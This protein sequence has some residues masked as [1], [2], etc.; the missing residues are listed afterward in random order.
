MERSKSGNTPV[1]QRPFLPTAASENLNCII[2]E[3]SG[4]QNPP[5]THPPKDGLSKLLRKT[6]VVKDNISIAGTRMTCGSRLLENY[7]SPFTATA[8]Q[9]LANAGVRF[10]GKTNLDEFAMGSSNE[11]SCFGPVPNPFDRSRVA[12]GSSGG[13]AA[14]AAAGLADFAL[15]SD[16][17]GS[18]R[19][20]AAFCGVLGFKPTFGR[21]SRYG[22]TAHASSL[23][24]IG[25]LSQSVELVIQAFLCM[26][27]PDERDST[28]LSGSDE[29]PHA[30]MTDFK[31][32]RIGAPTLPKESIDSEISDRL[33]WVLSEMEKSGC[34]I[35][36]TASI[37]WETNLAVYYILS[38]A[39]AATN[40]ARFDGI[41]YGKRESGRKLLGVYEES[42]TK[43][44]GPEVKRR[45]LIGNFV[46]TREHR[47]QYYEKA[48]HLRRRLCA[49]CSDLF[50]QYDIL[51]MPTAPHLPFRIGENIRHP[52][53]LYRSD[54]F[55]VPASLAGLPAI[56]IP[57][58]F[59][60]SGLPIG[61]QICGSPGADLFLLETAAKL[62]EKF[63]ISQETFIDSRH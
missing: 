19:Q 8:V 34:E 11:F 59:S 32:L 56:S 27:G 24:Q 18:V 53:R 15:G 7:I 14:A 35:H 63:P 42:R 13:S 30:A 44:F 47:G 23:D 48:Q 49:K 17:G 62:I 31:K 61:I 39:E 28:T 54:M 4:S 40:L 29:K 33:E 43:G 5:Q 55:T 20:P 41:R 6:C 26:A 9:R 58:G 57:M 1:S 10:T 51:L 50:R 16:T 52:L 25:I 12:G 45:I 21:I 37:D 36:R 2:S 38:A 60:G 46:L 3:I 22:L